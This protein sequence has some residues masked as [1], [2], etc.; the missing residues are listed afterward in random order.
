MKEQIKA[1]EKIRLSD[2]GIANLSH[3]QF[4]TL[5]IKMLTELI[6]H[7]HNMKEQ[8]KATQSEIKQNFRKPTVKGRKLGLISTV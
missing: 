2:E 8:T 5:V 7:G 6:E 1:P 3:A 4:K